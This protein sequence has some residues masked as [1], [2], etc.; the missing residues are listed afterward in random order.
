MKK[1]YEFCTITFRGYKQRKYIQWDQ[2]YPNTQT[3]KRLSS[4]SQ[5]CQTHCNAIDWSMPGLPAHRQLP[6][7]TQTH[8]HWVSDAIQLS[9]PLSSPFPPA[10]NISNESFLHIRW[11]KYWSFSFNI[12]PSNEHLRLISFR[13]DWLDFLAVQ[14]TL[15]SLLQ[16][17]SQKHQF[18]GTQLFL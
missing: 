5:S 8:V 7:L 12:S 1:F 4:V 17:H 13:V 14:R 3:K 2:N 10:F 16:H 9:H 6:E 18:F 11:P 15:K